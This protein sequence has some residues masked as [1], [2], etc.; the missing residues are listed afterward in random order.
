MLELTANRVE[1]QR[2]TARRAG[3][4][5]ALHPVSV[6]DRALRIAHE[7]RPAPLAAQLA[8]L[9]GVHDAAPIE[10]AGFDKPGYEVEDIVFKDITITKPSVALPLG[11]CRGVTLSNLACVKE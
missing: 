3:T 11:L 5:L 1:E 2:G 6:D 10:I 8:L 7:R 9:E 4:L